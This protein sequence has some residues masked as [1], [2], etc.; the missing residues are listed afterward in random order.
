MGDS[1]REE[2][3]A[4]RKKSRRSFTAR[5]DIDRARA[6]RAEYFAKSLARRKAIRKA[7][8]ARLF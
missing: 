1:Y 4:T 6:L 8:Q 2:I 5:T 7:T 3:K